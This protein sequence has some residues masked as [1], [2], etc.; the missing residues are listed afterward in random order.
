MKGPMRLTF[1]SVVQ[2]LVF[3]RTGAHLAPAQ[4][5]TRA[6]SRA[7]ASLRKQTRQEPILYPPGLLSSCDCGEISPSTFPSFH[8]SR[9]AFVHK[10]C[11]YFPQPSRAKVATKR[12]HDTSS[13]HR[14]ATSQVTFHVLRFTHPAPRNTRHG[15]RNSPMLPLI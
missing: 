8:F 12:N 13:N 3:P 4:G 15:T 11:P 14:Q 1:V 10:C 5:V 2:V 6:V 7:K 9:G